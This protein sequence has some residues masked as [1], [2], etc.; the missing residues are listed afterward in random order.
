LAQKINYKK[1]SIE[2]S[3]T[4]NNRAL[5]EKHLNEAYLDGQHSVMTKFPENP[6]ISLEAEMHEKKCNPITSHA[7]SFV[8][9]IRWIYDKIKP[10]LYQ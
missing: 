7:W 8:Q 10:K 4:K 3:S 9:G 2:I 5:I 1:L 6:F